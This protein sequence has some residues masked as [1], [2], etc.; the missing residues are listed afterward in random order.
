MSKY[1]EEYGSIILPTV[2]INPLKKALVDATNAQQDRLFD[3]ATKV[4]DHFQAVDATTGRKVRLNALKASIRKG[5]RLHQVHDE[6]YRAMDQINGS[7]RVAP[8][9]Y[10]SHSTNRWSSEEREEVTN[11]LVPHPKPGEPIK[12]VTP[13]KKSFPKLAANTLVFENEECSVTLVPQ[14]RKVIWRV[15]EGNR[16][17]ESARDST[18]GKAF[19]NALSKIKWTR[20]TGGV[21]RHTDEYAKDGAMEYGHSPISI[22]SQFGPEGEKAWADETGFSRRPSRRSPGRAPR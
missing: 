22:S 1:E 19:F 9:W 16:S 10:N 7:N 5:A 3:I 21:F 6:V 17:V 14:Q 2:A 15:E 18:L 12:L 11:L 4:F 13:L 20:G 8:S